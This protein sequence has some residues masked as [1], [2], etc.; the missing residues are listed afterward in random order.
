MSSSLLLPLL[1]GEA[2][3][4]GYLGSLRCPFRLLLSNGCDAFGH[5]LVLSYVCG[6]CWSTISQKLVVAGRDDFHRVD[7]WTPEDRDVRGFHVD[8][9][10]L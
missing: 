4:G 1:Q 2:L 7:P 3:V 10:E 9:I 5:G 6:F 8:H